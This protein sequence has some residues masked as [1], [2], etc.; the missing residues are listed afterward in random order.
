MKGIMVFIFLIL[1]CLNPGVI[2]AE[3]MRVVEQ[4]ARQ[5]REALA[6]KARK[7]L[8]AAQ[9]EAARSRARILS[10]RTALE[11][12]IA[13]LEADRDRLSGEVDLLQKHMDQLIKEEEKVT[14]KLEETDG[15]IRELVG[16]IRINARDIDALINQNPQSGPLG[17]SASFLSAVAENSRFPDMD[18]V[19][20]M[21]DALFAQIRRTG[22][23]TLLQSRMIDRSGRETE[24]DILLIGPFTAAY[25]LE[26][27]SGFLN[28][29][30]ASG[31]LYALSRPPG[32]R[33][34]KQLHHYMEGESEAVPMD[35]SR[36]GALR[37]LTHQVSFL[38]Q[39][40]RGG[41]IV[42]P[43]LAILALGLLIVI[44]RTVFLVRSHHRGPGP[45]T[46]LRTRS[47]AGDWSACIQ[48]CQAENKPVARVL[49]AGLEARKL[50]REDMEN[51]L[52]EA[53]LKEIPRLERFLSTLGMLAAIAPLLGLLGTV[54]GMINVFHVI[55][56]QGTSDPRLMSGGISE[57]L[58]TTMLGLS[59]AIPLM[60][61][62]NI[63]N[64][65]VDRLVGDMEEQ[66]VSLVN[67]IHKQRETTC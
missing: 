33:M 54:T 59:V 24:A 15:M 19:W 2:Q 62:H 29:A 31:T 21:A 52:Q 42:W 4:E 3:D 10:D 46:T 6:E 61:L 55:T 35:I 51:V 47:A 50:S 34:Q 25:R 49:A 37:Q 60:L 32:A 63:L 43:I 56:L 20:A 58:V 1:L 57:A 67:M 8:E 27:E 11:Q 14:G 9:E 22:E 36:G 13:E 53:L 7:E 65:S 5:T 17:H 28:H 40:G 41:P 44:E 38:E 39:I 66:S 48:A 23:V 45:M 64:R 18:D 26:G 16:M 12:A 30:Q